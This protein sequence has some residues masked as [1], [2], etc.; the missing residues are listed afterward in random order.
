M[1]SGSLVPWGPQ[2][3][4]RILIIDEKSVSLSFVPGRNG[5]SH[6]SSESWSLSQEGWSC[7]RDN[8]RPIQLVLGDLRFPCRM[9]PQE[10]PV[11]L[12]DDTKWPYR[13]K[14]PVS[15][16]APCCAAPWALPGPSDTLDLRPRSAW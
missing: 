7:P 13:R 6:V 9:F 11:N 5:E 4:L 3:F 16:H 8:T 10:G 1:G 2:Q 15:R 12:G 14:M